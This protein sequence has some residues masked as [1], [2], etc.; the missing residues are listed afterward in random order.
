[1]SSMAWVWVLIPIFAIVAGVATTWIRVSHGYPLRERK[2]RHAGE[3]HM[4]SAAPDEVKS[5]RE[6]L[7]KSDSKITHLE[8]RVRVLERIATDASAKLRDEIDRLR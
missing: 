6:A 7:A 2:G 5:L 8:E 1:M 3:W 4:P